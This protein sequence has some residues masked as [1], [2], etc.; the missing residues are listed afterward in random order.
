MMVAALL[1]AAMLSQVILVNRVPL[2]WDAAP[3]LVLLVVIGCALVRGSVRGAV[4]GF[5]AGLAVDVLPPSAHVVG[6]Y[7]L[8]FCVVGFVA[9]RAAERSS[10]ATVPA[11]IGCAVLGPL[12]A[13][14]VSMLLGDPRITV[15]A[16]V[17]TVPLAVVYNLLAAPLVVWG[18]GRLLGRRR[19]RAVRVFGDPAR[20]RM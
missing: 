15:E 14:V 9:G 4:I 6:Q 7:A 3:D 12:L 20:S 8:V 1:V 10:S 16:M 5:C 18:V 11:A 13:A 2:P 19:E 17:A